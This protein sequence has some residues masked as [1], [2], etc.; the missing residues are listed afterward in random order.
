[1]INYMPQSGLPGRNRQIPGK[2]ESSKSESGKNRK[3][4]NNN[5]KLLMKS[6]Q[7]EKLSTNKRLGPSGFT[8]E[9][10]NIK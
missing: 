2:I 10:T 9:F 8:G 6:K 4:E 1:M 5:K 7:Q 3:S